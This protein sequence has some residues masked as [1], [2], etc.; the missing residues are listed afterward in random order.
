MTNVC[1]I[2]GCDYIAVVKMVITKSHIKYLKTATILV[3]HCHIEPVS[4]FFEFDNAPQF[5]SLEITPI[6]DSSH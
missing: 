2:K 1:Q 6:N 5:N 4:Y 3:C